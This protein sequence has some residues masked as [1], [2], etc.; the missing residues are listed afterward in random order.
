MPRRG[1]RA[2]VLATAAGIALAVLAAAAMIAYGS[3]AQI[4]AWTLGGTACL[5]LI[6]AGAPLALVLAS[7]AGRLREAPG[8]LRLLEEIRG[9]AMLSDHA[10]RVL[11]RDRE[12]D[13]LRGAIEDHIG[14]GDHNAAIT[15]CDDLANLFGQRGQAETYRSRIAEVRAYQYDTEVQAAL[16]QFESAL[17]GHD[18]SA[19]HQQA[20]RIRRLYPESYQVADLDRRIEAARAEHKGV[21]EARF[22]EAA[23][24]EDAEAAMGLLK[25]LDRYLGRE[26]AQ[27]LTEVAQGVI[28]RHRDSL[29]ARFRRAVSE[30][31]W[32]EAVRLGEVLAAE[33]PNS[34]MASE[35]RSMMDVLRARAGQPAAAG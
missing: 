12:L 30:R 11:F 10:R 27:R 26:E 18:W 31:R 35:V 21:L 7:V 4:P 5:V 28:V 34:Q 33:F 25:Q 6:L 19:V 14:R 20:A 23:E 3:G 8:A 32:A 1:H 15:L 2:P 17:A 24:H 9:H 16:G 13:L 22:L 29:G